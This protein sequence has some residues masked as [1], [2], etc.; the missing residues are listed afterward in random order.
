MAIRKADPITD[1]VSSFLKFH[2]FIIYLFINQGSL[3][4]VIICLQKLY[5]SHKNILLYR[6]WKIGM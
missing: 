6:V 2:S 5:I 1:T 4:D 3:T